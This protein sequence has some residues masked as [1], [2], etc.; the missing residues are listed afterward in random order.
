[1]AVPIPAQ[2]ADWARWLRL[3]ALLAAVAWGCAA[4]SRQDT[5][6][7]ERVLFGVL[8]GGQVQE[9]KEIP[10]ELDTSKQS[11]GFRIEARASDRVRRIRW[12]LTR[13]SS[14]GDPTGRVTELGDTLLPAN[15]SSFE[16]VLRF[17]P[18]DPLGLHNIRILLDDRVVLDRPF[19][20][21]DPNK[22]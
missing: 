10:F 3:G 8:F 1:M 13:P 20:V 11:V 18:G 5:T 21:Y 17:E 22:R 2:R 15:Q 6:N 16:Q 9:R 7:E 14:S 19:V 4:C 12:E